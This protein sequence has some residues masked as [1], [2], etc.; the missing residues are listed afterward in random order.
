[1]LRV[2]QSPSSCVSLMLLLLRW[3]TYII[4]T[5]RMKPVRFRY[6]FWFRPK[7][8]DV[9]FWSTA[10]TMLLL[11][12]TIELVQRLQLTGVRRQSWG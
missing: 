6:R 5:V 12:H 3:S 10:T 2:V 4:H 11:L 8:K 9:H 7:V 1:M